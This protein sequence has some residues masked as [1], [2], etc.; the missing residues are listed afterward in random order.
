M[1]F[2]LKV[3]V[4]VCIFF[5]KKCACL[6]LMRFDENEESLEKS[7]L[8]LIGIVSDSSKKNEI[9]RIPS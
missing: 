3:S 9:L 5:L 1:G 4:C 6:T 8:R 7:E 2:F